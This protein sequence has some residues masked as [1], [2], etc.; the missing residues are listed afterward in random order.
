MIDSQGAIHS[1]FESMASYPELKYSKK[2]INRAGQILSDPIIFTPDK[3][4]ENEEIFRIANNWRECHA[5]P[6]R[7]LRLS[8]MHK[9]RHLGVNGMTA[10]RLKRMASIRKKLSRITSNLDQINDLAGCRA[11]LESIADVNALVEGCKSDFRHTLR[12]R[13][14][15]YINEPKADGYRS[16]HLIF[17]YSGRREAKKYDGMRVELQIRTRLQHSW[18]TAVE[19]VGLFRNED[20]K[21]GEGNAGWLRL[22][23]LMSDEFAF[24]EGCEFAFNGRDLRIAEIKDLNHFLGAVPVLENIRKAT[25]YAKQ[26]RVSIH[27]YKPKYYVIRYDRNAHTVDVAAYSGISEGSLSFNT[28]EGFVEM[29]EE[30]ASVVFVEVDKIESLAEAYPNYFGDVSLFIENLSRIC[31]GHIALEYSMAPKEVIQ[32]KE[33]ELPIDPSWL[34]PRRHSWQWGNKK[35]PP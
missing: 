5:F 17:G 10:A 23:K 31:G 24:A 12:G 28:L 20:M 18:A 7:G 8:V 22:F 25:H 1:Y 16:H 29:G 33:K 14:Y 11:I 19:A 34:R 9:M 3:Q 6:M 27:G 13:A 32:P 21:A 2:E 26:H 30:D 4:A 35:P 15:D